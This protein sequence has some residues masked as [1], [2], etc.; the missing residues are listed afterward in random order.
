MG[1]VLDSSVILAALLRRDGLC[2]RL[3]NEGLKGAFLIC[4]SD[5]IIAEIKTKLVEKGLAENIEIE[6]ALN[7]LFSMALVCDVS[8]YGQKQ[9]ADDEHIIGCF[10]ECSADLIVTLDKRLIQSLEKKG[11]AVAHPGL[12]QHYFEEL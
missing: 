3:V 6:R 9:I 10:K 8:S 7:D 2:A 12:F 5:A 1:V 4:L 11:I